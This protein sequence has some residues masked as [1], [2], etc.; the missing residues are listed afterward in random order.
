MFYFY[1]FWDIS[2][3]TLN[4]SLEINIVG[5]GGAIIFNQGLIVWVV[6]IRGGGQTSW[7]GVNHLSF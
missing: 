4:L 7:L 6:L 5:G 1:S 3:D 2:Y